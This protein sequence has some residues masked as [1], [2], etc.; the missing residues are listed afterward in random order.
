MTASGADALRLSL[1]GPASRVDVVV[2]SGSLPGDVLGDAPVAVAAALGVGLPSRWVRMDGVALDPLRPLAEQDVR[3]GDFLVVADLGP[4]VR[5]PHPWTPPEP[6]AAPD[7]AGPRPRRGGLAAAA[8]LALVGA[9]GAAASTSGPVRAAAVATPILAVAAVVVVDRVAVA[10]RTGGWRAGWPGVRRAAH[11]LGPAAV[12]AAV[13][14][15]AGNDGSRGPGSLLGGVVAA[16][17]AGVAAAAIRAVVPRESARDVALGVWVLA[18]TLVAFVFAAVLVAAAP[19]RAV[20]IAVV[21]VAVGA[22]RILADRVVRVPDEALLELTRLSVT[23]WSAHA[24]T[25]AGAAGRRRRF[26][27]RAGEVDAL[28]DRA[29][30]LARAWS[31]AGALA[32]AAG[33]I[34]MAAMGAPPGWGRYAM[35]VLL[36]AVGLAMLLG[37]RAERDTVARV[38]GA[39]GGGASL[40]AALV[41]TGQVV[42]AP[43]QAWGLAATLAA[44]AAAAVAAVAAGRGWRSLNAARLADAMEGLSVAAVLP[45]G[46]VAAGAAEWVT[47][48]TW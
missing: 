46:L 5:D 24:D 26:R 39:A 30:D 37:S 4:A 29:A 28:V 19:P 8:M 43:A 16:I 48:W 32:V 21:V 44:G 3:D 36:W 42:P 22:L 15:A 9:A 34:A 31:V 33:T 40:V 13:W 7:D 14:L 47:Q 18:G 27:V 35:P 23:A 25:Q 41:V 2:R 11:V 45:A 10:G 38:A 17:V 12:G 6:A 20:P 1:V